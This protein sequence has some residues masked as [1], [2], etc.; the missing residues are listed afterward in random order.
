MVGCHLLD[1]SFC[2]FSDCREFPSPATFS[3]SL[4]I[5]R[6][7]PRDPHEPRSKSRVVAEE[8]KPSV[9]SNERLLGNIFRVGLVPQNSKSDPSGQ[10][11][12][13]GQALLKLLSEVTVGVRAHGRS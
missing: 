7:S 9:G 6:Q 3:R 1:I 12:R 10:C 5:K 11:A 13:L 8:P 2:A 4:V